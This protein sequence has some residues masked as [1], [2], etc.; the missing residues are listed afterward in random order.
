M[1]SNLLKQCMAFVLAISFSTIVVAQ[2]RPMIY[3]T[4]HRNN[5]TERALT[6]PS[7]N[8]DSNIKTSTF[9]KSSTPKNITKNFH[10]DNGE[11]LGGMGSWFASNIEGLILIP[12]EDLTDYVGQTID[13]VRF[14]L[15]D[16]SIITE[17]RLIIYEDSIAGD[18]VVSE[19][20]T[21]NLISGWN[22]A[23]FSTGYEIPEAT[24]IF[25]GVGVITNGEGQSIGLDSDGADAPAYSGFVLLDDL[26]MTLTG[27]NINADFN[28]Q[29]LITDGEDEIYDLGITN[30]ET[31]SEGC[32]L[33]DQEIIKV[34]L[35]NFG[36]LISG[37]FNLTVEVN[38]TPL[39]VQVSPEEFETGTEMVVEVASFDMSA[40][41]SYDVMASFDF[42]DDIIGNNTF[43]TSF[44]SG[45]GKLTI[46]LLTD[47]LP[48]ETSWEL[49]DRDGNVV[50][51]NGLLSP[52][53][54]DITDIC[55]ANNNCYTW[56]IYDSF[57]DGIAGYNGSPA[58][59]FKIYI[60]GELVDES[61]EGGNFGY[62]YSTYNLGQ[63]CS[64]NNI[65]LTSINMPDQSAPGLTD[66]KGTVTNMGSATLTSFDVVY[67]VE[68]YTSPIFT[69]SDINIAIGETYSFTHDTPYDFET[70][71]T[72]SVEVT[73][74]NPNGVEDENPDDNILIH[75]ISII[76]G[77]IPRIQLFEHFTSS[78]CDPCAS[79]TPKVDALLDA[80]EGKYSLIRY[81]VYWPGN[82]DPYYIPA[83]GD[84]VDYY[85]VAG[86][87]V[88]DVYRNGA[89]NMDVT[90]DVFDQIAG[91][92]SV[93]NLDVTAEYTGEEV[94]VGLDITT[95]ADLEAG[96]AAHIVIVENT[97]VGN[98]GTN[99]E[100]EFRNVIMAMLPSSAGT[101]L[102]AIGSGE[103]V[104][105]T[106]SKDMSQTFVEEMNDL[107]AVVFIQDNESKEV[108][109][110]IMVPVKEATTQVKL[111]FNVDMANAENFTPGTDVVYVTG[112][113]S[114]WVAPGAEGSLLM[115]DDD[116]DMIYS[117]ETMVDVNQTVEYKYF[118]NAGLDGGESIENR[119]A[120]I[121]TANVTQN[122]VWNFVT[123]IEDAELSHISIFPNP[124]N[125]ILTLTNL[126]NVEKIIVSNILGQKVQTYDVDTETLSLSTSDF[127][128]GVY[129]ITIINHN[130]NTTTKRIIKK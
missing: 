58:G 51:I 65:E 49:T 104:T 27:Q 18:P 83:S 107:T 9:G 82:G 5:F 55:I 77:L 2:T 66:I 64:E 70:E 37:S 121:E 31:T 59:Y 44:M 105:I 102:N 79:F 108:L 92:T 42:E 129:L 15:D 124:F 69:V 54:L 67:T 73:V 103:T 72:Y 88:P 13:A 60:D 106:E 29:A 43:A 130:S 20:V 110:S 75:N 61:P 22:I 80:N 28:I 17:V 10:Y 119:L 109:Q 113:F 101:T 115:S 120:P 14:G 89:E 112:S 26:L 95:I 16:L 19:T 97:T 68:N 85:G 6:K 38:E 3:S 87:G 63:G 56:T 71:G 114:D 34:T 100:T 32:S 8:K 99:G 4:H 53:A 91:L 11:I 12:K 39:T 96:L 1:K 94:N 128:V 45:D 118:I 62:E 33:S 47:A 84:R 46:E 93:I 41:G 90:Q 86:I 7:L 50:A 24:N 98:V 125:D 126:N 36:D 78:T 116:G 25:I 57:G 52:E 122:D 48:N 74:S 127:N 35:A 123:S 30:I 23:K 117:A 40:L 111:T 21:N 76:T 81:Q